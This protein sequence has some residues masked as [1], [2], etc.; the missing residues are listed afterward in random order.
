MITPPK[1]SLVL[2]KYLAVPFILLILGF[3]LFSSWNVI[4]EINFEE[5]SNSKFISKF[6]YFIDKSNQLTLA[7]I[8]YRKDEFISAKMQDIPYDLADET[9]WLTINIDSLSNKG[10]ALILYADNSLLDVFEIYQKNYQGQYDH[11][12]LANNPTSILNAYPHI[13]FTL[14]RASTQHFIIKIKTEGPPNVPLMVLS[15]EDF[16]QRI[17]YAQMVYGAFIG[18]ILLMALYNIVLY[19]AIKDKVYLVYIGYL[20]SAFF[21]LSSLTGFGYLIFPSEI[22]S[23]INQYLL[24]IDYYLVIFLLIFTLL[25]LRYE[26]TKGKIYHL[27]ITLSVVLFICSIYSL[28]LDTIAQTKLFFSLQPAIYIFALLAISRRIK[29]D[30]SWAKFYLLSWGPLL[31]GAAIQPLVLLNYLEY[32]F[33]T[34]NAFLFAILAEITLMAFALAERMKRNEQDRLCDI[35]YHLASGLPRKSNVDHCIAQ[36]INNGHTNFSVLIIKPDHIDQVALY[37]DDKMNTELFKH[38]YQK[39]SSLVNFNDAVCS[40]TDKQEKLCF[41]NNNSLALVIDNQKSHQPLTT[42]IQSVQQVVSDNFQLAQLK[43]PL[44]AIIGV[45]NFPE[46]GKASHLL[47]NHAQLALTQA[48]LNHEKWSVFQSIS[49]DKTAYLLNLTAELNTAIEN[50]QL[51]IY[52]QPQIDLKTLRVCSSECLLRWKI[53][54]GESI[55][56]TIFVPLA[57][58]MGLINQLTL[59][60]IKRALSQ[61]LLLTDE[62]GY[63]HMVSI[64][65]SGKDLSSKHFF[66]DVLDIIEHSNIAAEKI[67]FELTESA[68]FSDNQQALE[69]INN[70][71]ELGL[72]ISIDDFGTGYSSMSQ[73]SNLPFQELKVDRQFVEN[74]C[75]D[76]KRNVNAKA[77]LEMAK[78][79]GLE[80]VAEGIN[81]QEDEDALR[82]F[83]CDIGQGYYYAKPMALDDYIDWLARL[84]NGQIPKSIQGEFIPADK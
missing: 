50:D 83:G 18:I 34:R 48:E 39:L 55:P 46:H 1:L 68:S 64:N 21:V 3:I 72:T 49:S 25:F 29:S 20:L 62:H 31:I 47:L 35:A 71:T 24:F 63:N 43:L 23:I 5:R 77:T 78:G 66:S 9:Y 56:P 11:I 27:G 28:S 30:F 4:D 42:V 74:V 7:K 58:D 36:L 59:W 52:H 53:S 22:Q 60:V 84:T 81:S 73:V 2:T 38:L 45:A 70:L 69:V 14:P 82:Q 40:L 75:Q 67:I 16:Q 41:I 57:E 37:I 19:F 44:T 15:Q 65:I 76:K 10:Q 79:L 13:A 17:A 54:S 8:Q 32:S 26:Q 6:N 33:L 51:E 80:V 12:N 61:Q